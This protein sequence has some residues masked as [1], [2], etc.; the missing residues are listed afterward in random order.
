M[1][2]TILEGKTRNG[3]DPREIANS[4]IKN[5]GC[6]CWPDGSKTV[7]SRFQYSGPGLDEVDKLC[8]SLYIKQKCLTI[9]ARDG[10]YNG[11]DCEANNKFRWYHDSD[12]NQLFCGD[13]FD[14]GYYERKPCKI[15]NCELEREFVM[16]VYNLYV[17][18]NFE[19]NS[20]YKNMSDTEYKDFCPS[21]KVIGDTS[22]DKML[23]CCGEGTSRRPFNLIVKECC[24]NDSGDE[25]DVRFVGSCD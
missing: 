7:S 3:E 9:D 5:Y 19:P 10:V 18:E 12:S 1:L 23:G 21:N 4:L 8:R 20:E 17:N 14:I 15:N 22:P 13:E 6:Y 25:T 2:S 16:G 24:V 11:N